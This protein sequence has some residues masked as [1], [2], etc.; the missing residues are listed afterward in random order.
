MNDLQNR[1]LSSFQKKISSLNSSQGQLQTISLTQDEINAWLSSQTFELNSQKISA[2]T[3][4]DPNNL[5]LNLNSGILPQ[6]SLFIGVNSDKKLRLNGG[7]VGGTTLSIS[8]FRDK[9]ATLP[10]GIGNY[11]FDK[12]NEQFSSLLFNNNWN[13]NTVILKNQ[14]VE[15]VVTK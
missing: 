10:L 9:L 3:I 5:K 1:Y 7:S 6:V 4:V 12:L 8:D 2:Y 15:L 13:I 14:E 11:N